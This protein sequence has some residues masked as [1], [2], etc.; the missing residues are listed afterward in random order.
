MLGDFRPHEQFQRWLEQKLLSFL[1][2]H[3]KQ[4]RFYAHILEKVY[5]LNLDRLLPL[6]L[7]RYSFT[8]RPAQN[9]PETFRALVV[10]GHYKEGITSFVGRLRAHPVLAVL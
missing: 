7:G 6:A 5:V 8:G 3:E 10:M 2:Q 1:P 4:I 9:Q